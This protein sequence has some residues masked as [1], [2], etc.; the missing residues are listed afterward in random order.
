MTCHTAKPIITSQHFTETH[1]QILDSKDSVTVRVLF[2]LLF[3]CYNPDTMPLTGSHFD[4]VLA[5]SYDE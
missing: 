3:T 4:S 5:Q 1:L 2:L